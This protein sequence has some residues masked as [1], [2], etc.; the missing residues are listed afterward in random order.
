MLVRDLVRRFPDAAAI[1]ARHGLEPEYDY[2]SIELAA[3]ASQRDPK[4]L[5]TSLRESLLDDRPAA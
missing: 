1:L 3:E 4:P 2:L 5:L